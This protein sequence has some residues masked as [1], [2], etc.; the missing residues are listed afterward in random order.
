[1]S[2]DQKGQ[3]EKSF[4]LLPLL[5]YALF[6]MGLLVVLWIPF[7]R[8]TFLAK[9]INDFSHIPLFGLVAL[10]TLWVFRKVS[11][12]HHSAGRSYLL[13]FVSVLVIAGLS[14]WVQSWTASRSPSI[15]DFAYDVLGALCALGLYATF[16]AH[17]DRKSLGW[18][19][20]SRKRLIRVG[21]G[22]VLVVTLLPVLSW[23]Y[24]FYDRERRFPI[25]CQFTSPW[26]M[27]FVKA[28]GSTLEVADSPKEWG[29]VSGDL[30]G[31]VRFQTIRYPGF[32]LE[33]PYP[34]W[35][36]FSSF[37]LEVYSDLP[38]TQEL[39]L[40]IDDRSHNGNH[41]DRF[42]RVLL[43]S[44]GLNR[45]SVSLEEVREALEGR[46]LDLSAIQTV[47]LFAVKP[48][49]PFTLYVDN[50]RLE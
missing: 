48:P 30:V 5:G 10:M 24:A 27:K 6:I 25:L 32:R 2:L 8:P 42:N 7:P 29:K 3:K 15:W 44:P 33:E 18:N 40:R 1:M 14:E 13:S 35:R 47:L 20:A 36:G 43:I 39:V 22:L 17:L 12:R 11:P 34:D 49:E 31:K 50:L 46:Q 28:F 26:E 23:S 19:G 9:A 37:S 38:H 4:N 45:I 41:T 16:D 21:I